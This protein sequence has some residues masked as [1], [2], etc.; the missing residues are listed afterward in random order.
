M[1]RLAWGVVGD[2][3][4]EVS[5]DRGVLYLPG[6]SGVVWNGLISV[7]ETPDGADY[8]PYY[9]DGLKYLHLTTKEEFEATV[10]ALSAPP[11]F[12]SC[13]GIT[14]IQNG[15]FVTEQARSLFDF[16]YRTFVGNDA[17]GREHAYKIHL[18]YSALAQPSRRNNATLTSES[19][20]PMVL[21]WVVTTIPQVITGRFPSSHLVIDSRQYSAEIMSDVEDILYGTNSTDPSM[22]TPDELVAVLEP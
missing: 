9:I 12:A 6:E 20:D 7:T 8:K 1:S 15:L 2:R 19:A 10:N 16:T 22:P 13:D 5:V 3:F 17:E 21:S 14:S 18:V 11:E 4:F